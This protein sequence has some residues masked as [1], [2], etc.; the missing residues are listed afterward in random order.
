MQSNNH[1]SIEYYLQL[2]VKNSHINLFLLYFDKCLI[3][4]FERP[5]VML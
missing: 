1:L 3:L 5:P 4:V 2:L